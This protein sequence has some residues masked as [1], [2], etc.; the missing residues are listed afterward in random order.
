M[1]LL[2][3]ILA[4]IAALG[5]HSAGAQAQEQPEAVYAKFH[6]ATLSG[7]TDS[8]LSFASERRKAELASKSRAEKD[9][10][11][12]FMSVTM[13]REYRITGKVVASDGN[14]AMLRAAGEGEL[15]GA[16]APMYL[17]ARFVKEAGV[18]KVDEWAWTGDKPA[19]EASQVAAADKD[20]APAKGKPPAKPPGP[21]T[22]EVKPS[23]DPATLPPRQVFR[24]DCVYKPVMSDDEM[25]ACGATPPR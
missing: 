11:I 24:S 12:K 3:L 2:Q 21:G 23:P 6:R 25:R 8:V 16:K 13:P 5:L 19:P 1:R 4:S 17:N 14:I 20:K 22:L 7:H 10:V 15:L 18:W 9:Y